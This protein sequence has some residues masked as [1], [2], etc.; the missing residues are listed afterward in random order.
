MLPGKSPTASNSTKY[1]ENAIKDLIDSVKR[2]GVKTENLEISVVGGGNVL[3]EGDIPDKVINSVLY[4]LKKLNL[5]PKYMRVGGIQR[6]SVYLDIT[7][8]N[9]FY[10]EGNNTT[11]L[12][13]KGKERV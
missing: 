1:A 3:Q 6:R 7:S 8:G 13:L 12:L 9:V 5:I 11:R 4:Y 10:T 2:L